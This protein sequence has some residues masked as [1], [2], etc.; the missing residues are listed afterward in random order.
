LRAKNVNDYISYKK[1][2]IKKKTR[3]RFRSSNY[4]QDPANSFERKKFPSGEG[5]R[6]MGS[7]KVDRKKILRK[8]SFHLV[9]G[10]AGV[11]YSVL[12]NSPRRE[13]WVGITVGGG[14]KRR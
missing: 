13:N 2:K 4:V 11:P 6:I 3:A 9:G 5:Y 12:G 8:V 14:S 7:G 1:S 10:E